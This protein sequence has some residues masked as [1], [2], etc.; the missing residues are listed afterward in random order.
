MLSNKYSIWCKKVAKSYQTK[1]RV[2]VYPLFF[3]CCLNII[4]SNIDIII[5]LFEWPSMY[6]TYYLAL[7]SNYIGINIRDIF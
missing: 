6:S 2:L 3:V 1:T 5:C 4:Y 7:C